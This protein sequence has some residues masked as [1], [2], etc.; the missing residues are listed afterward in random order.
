MN[1]PS[2]D[3]TGMLVYNG[4]NFIQALEGPKESVTQLFEKIS[5]D[6]RHRNV[7]VL[8]SG[9]IDKREFPDW[10]MKIIDQGEKKHLS[11]NNLTM[12]IKRP[13][14]EAKNDVRSAQ[15]IDWFKHTLIKRSS[16][17]I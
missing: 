11:W 5:K 17:Q 2:L 8:L 6:E 9:G 7:L 1:N 16:H 15:L 10:A 4:G 3:I 12:M 13:L 14:T